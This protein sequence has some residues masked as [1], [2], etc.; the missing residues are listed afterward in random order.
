VGPRTDLD[1]VE[2]IFTLLGLEL[3]TLGRAASSQSPYRLRYPGYQLNDIQEQNIS[4]MKFTWCV[5]VLCLQRQICI[6]IKRESRPRGR[7]K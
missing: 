2:K 3:R 7:P 5:R 4:G 1:D 6:S